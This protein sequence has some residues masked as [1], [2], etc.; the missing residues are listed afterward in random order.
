MP[1]Q[2]AVAPA[3]QQEPAQPLQLPKLTLS[4]PKE[5]EVQYLCSTQEDAEVPAV[6]DKVGACLGNTRGFSFHRLCIFHCL[7][8][9]W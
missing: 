3:H 7:S 9:P 1:S 5:L 4:F 6:G 2:D 8:S